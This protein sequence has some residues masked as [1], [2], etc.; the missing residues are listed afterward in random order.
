MD[1]VFC[2]DYTSSMAAGFNEIREMILLICTIILVTNSDVRIGLIK[3]RSNHDPWCT[4]VLVFT[5]KINNLRKWLHDDEPGGKT[6]D[7]CEDVG[8]KK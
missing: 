4:R 8:K 2:I 7:K 6:P 5:R 1:I 3:F